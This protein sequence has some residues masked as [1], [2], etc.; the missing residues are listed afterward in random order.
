MIPDD[1]PDAGPLQS[2]PSHVV[3]GDLDDLLET[4]HAWMREAGELVHRH[5]TQR[6]HKLN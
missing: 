3:V 5:G 2:D 1:L 4:K 6:L